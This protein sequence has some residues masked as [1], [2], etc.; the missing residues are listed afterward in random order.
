MVEF[1]RE[2]EKVL[3]LDNRPEYT[4]IVPETIQ[5]QSAYQI[6]VATSKDKL[7]EDH[8]DIW[9]SGKINDGNSVEIEHN[10]QN[11]DDTSSYCWKVR[12]WGE[13]MKEPSAFSKVQF[14]RTGII[15]GYHATS[16]IIQ[17]T[18]I[19]PETIFRIDSTHYFIDF[20]KDAFGQLGMVLATESDD[21]LII[22][23]GEKLSAT[24]QIDTAPGGS[25]R[26]QKIRLPVQKGKK[27]YTVFPERNVRNTSGSAVLLPD[28]I[29]IATPFRYCEIEGLNPEMK[30]EK[31]WQNAYFYYFDDD[32]AY[33]TSSDTLLNTIWNFCKYSIKATS[34]AG[35][36]VDGDRERIPYEG[37]AYI[38]QLGHYCVDREYSMARRTNEYF[39]KNPT[40]PTEWILH[41]V[42]LFYNDYLYTGNPESLEFNYEDL[43]YKTLTDLAR[44]DGLISS[45]NASR[46]LMQK[47]GFSNPD[48]RMRD[49]VDW[50]PAQKDTGWKLDTPEGERDGYEMVEINTVVNSFYYKNLVLMSEIASW[51]NKP[52]DA[53]YF[54]DKAKQ[55]KATINTKLFDKDKG[56]YV[57]GEG[58]KHSSL[59]ANMMPLAFGL[60][61]EEHIPSVVAFIKTRGMA[62]SVYG[63][64]YLMEGLFEAGEADYALELLTST[65][66]R[67]WYNMI[68]SGSSITMEA[69]DMKYKPN[70]DWNH[71]WGAAPANIIPRGLW[72]IRPAKPG[73][74]KVIIKPQPGSL[75][76]S[77]IKVPTIRGPVYAEFKISETQVEFII[78]LPPNMTGV[79]VIPVKYRKGKVFQDHNLLKPNL[80]TSALKSG[81][82]KITIILK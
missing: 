56:I 4:W 52:D 57:D 37:D 65:N 78:Q 6:L 38:N 35:L 72:G 15:N 82:N 59:H 49:L 27:Q 81:M 2:P 58:S 28:T 74:S 62:C 41:T 45:R 43:K 54:R 3:I 75:S 18:R 26:Y 70:A 67:S 16:N 66:D 76:H 9:N 31:I 19:E 80:E 79:F 17:K 23:L 22:H 24:H 46:E 32:A 39:I 44:A 71:A 63:A 12:V 47:L 13:G 64:Q 7:E 77:K 25:V 42:P 10:G 53:K 60:V 30:P 34:F 5:K 1:I 36:Y 48:T 29:G 73:F 61:P 21:T 33:F 14:F 69:W 20:G 11:L 51:L 55:V 68:R 50:P 8:A 40:W